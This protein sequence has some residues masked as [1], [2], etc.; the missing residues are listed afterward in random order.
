M[1]NVSVTFRD[2]SACL[3]PFFHKTLKHL[4]F[5]WLLWKQIR[6]PLEKNNNTQLYDIHE[7]VLE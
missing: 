2:A 3:T 1:L 5:F 6:H 7:K 4:I